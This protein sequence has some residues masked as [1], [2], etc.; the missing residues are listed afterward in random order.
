MN[1]SYIIYIKYNLI[2]VYI[3]LMTQRQVY[4]CMIH[5]LAVDSRYRMRKIADDI[6]YFYK[7]PFMIRLTS[8]CLEY[9]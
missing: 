5:L 8:D 4:P 9:K 1:R 6:M 2:Y 7:G 3:K